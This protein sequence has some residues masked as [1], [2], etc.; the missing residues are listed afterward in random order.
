MSNADVNLVIEPW[1]T[2]NTHFNLYVENPG[3]DEE[4]LVAEFA[5]EK[6]PLTGEQPFVKLTFIGKYDPDSYQTGNLLFNIK[7][8][9][10][11]FHKNDHGIKPDSKAGNFNVTATL[12][13]QTTCDVGLSM[14]QSEEGSFSFNFDLKN[15]NGG[16]SHLFDPVIVI[17]RPPQ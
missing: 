1:T 17:I 14:V 7:T 15:N 9:G 11:T 3:T 8:S 2:A 5:G 12:Q 13:T 16:K 4:F 10:Y 6:F